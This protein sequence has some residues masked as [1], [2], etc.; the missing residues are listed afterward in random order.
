MTT[1]FALQSAV[2]FPV[3]LWIESPERFA[4]QGCTAGTFKVYLYTEDNNP[5][6]VDLYAQGS[7]SIP[8]QDPQ[9][10]WS[11]LNPQ[12]KFTDL[13]GNNVNSLT[14]SNAVTAEFNGTTGYKSSGEFYYY[15]DMPTLMN[16]DVVLIWGVV[17]FLDYPAQKDINV[18]AQWVPSYAN[19][20]VIAIAPYYI[21]ALI[22]TELVVYR[23][24][25]NQMSDFYWVDGLIPHVVSVLGTSEMDS[26]TAVMK[27]V[28]PTNQLGLSG[29][30]I[31]RSVPGISSSHLSWTPS[32]TNSYLSAADYQDFIVGG[33][34]RSKVVS[35]ITANNVAISA[36]GDVW[37]EN[38]PV[39][40]PYLWI[41][42]PE[43]NT[44]NRV[45][46]PCIP[47]EWITE[48]APF[49]I[50]L[51]QKVY[52]TSYMQVTGPTVAMMLTG[53]HGVYGIAIDEFKNVWLAD[54]ENDMVYK[55][56]PYGVRLSSINF[57]EDNSYGFI[58]G[59]C[60]P[61]SITIDGTNNIWVTFF[62]S[63]STVYI[64]STDGSIITTINPGDTLG[65][66]PCAD[67]LFKPV[68]AEP[69]NQNNVWVTYNNT[70]C[71]SL[72]KYNTAG[73]ILATITLP[74]CSNPM[75]IF[76]TKY[77][78]VWVSLT[79]YA[80]AP[81][82][83]STINKY[84]S[85]GTSIL[86]SF[87]AFNPAYLAMDGDESLW[88]TQR[89]NML[90]RITSA[91]VISNWSVGT[92]GPSSLIPPQT[93]TYEW[94]VLEG[95]CCDIYDKVWIINSVENQLY[96]IRN[97]NVVLGLKI[98]PDQNLTWCNDL[99][100]IYT[101]VNENTKSAQA[102]G[103]WSGNRWIRKYGNLDI[104]YLSAGLVGSSSTFN[105]YDFNGYDI[106]RFNE[107]WDASNEIKKFARSPHIAD[108]PKFWDGYMKA[109]WGDASTPQGESF[110]RETYERISN[111]PINHI[112]IN[113]CNISQLYSLAQYTDVPIDV[114][115]VN[116]PSELRRIMDIGSINQQL[117]WGSRCKCSKNITNTYT[118]Y[119][120]A[121]Q[122]V[123][124]NYLCKSC[125]HMH[126]GN[127]GEQFNPLSYM[128]TAFVPFIV[129]DRT[130]PNN[131]FQL[132]TP[133]ASCLMVSSYDTFGDICESTPVSSNCLTTYPLSSY[134]HILLPSVFNYG[135]SANWDDF[136]QAVTYFCFYDYIDS[137]PCQTQI[138]GIINWDDQ[139]TT[140]NENASSIED[141]YGSGQT[142]E[143]IINYVLHKGLGLI[144]N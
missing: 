86:S 2:N 75:D 96:T 77:N 54:A 69:D 89:G 112:D 104:T 97:D 101:E 79:H 11:H 127:K 45:F 39:H 10:K 94:N 50:E 74:T 95:L 106:R 17:D 85:A 58:S 84:F 73:N 142:L 98:T 3:A 56:D 24:G 7:H 144:G 133:P 128:V 115:G 72:V 55:L 40:Y 116:F 52:D 30:P 33:Y 5:H 23:D 31:I 66:I 35:D 65:P 27:N 67:P 48:D 78:D 122:L 41:S 102:F 81:Y 63:M 135:T 59:G 9:N 32:N 93:D 28:P 114:Y 99:G 117:L 80:G 119:M 143:K 109:V 100:Y 51:G 64:N 125:G 18:N 19:S 137:T 15:D 118:T 134:Y 13:S 121:Q 140:L 57:G 91:G 110:G 120:S 126:P 26:C 44:M 49:M 105:I 29:G 62:D 138:A 22:P 83:M 76:I 88:F 108:N 25:L 68:L 113:A 90:T 4:Y 131:K 107:S 1:Q 36:T 130:N 82:G 20:K 37:Y 47:D 87:P 12:W 34:I 16:C 136:Q 6:R 103:D 124:T 141:W 123:E 61:S 71:S 42:N 60:T 38:I 92:Q 8:Y 53:F 111:F 43:N 129:D 21:N 132:I 139:Y 14:L 46:A 70:L